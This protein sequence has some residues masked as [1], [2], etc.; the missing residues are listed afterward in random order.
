LSITLQATD[1]NKFRE[2]YPKLSFN[3]K[4]IIYS[5]WYQLFPLQNEFMFD[6]DF[7][8]SVIPQKQKLKV[9]EYGGYEGVLANAYLELYPKSSWVNIELISHVNHNLEE[10][11]YKEIVLD[12]ELWETTLSFTADLFIAEHTIEHL[13]DVECIKFV[14][15]LKK[16]NF[17]TLIIGAPLEEEGQTWRDYYGGHILTFGSKKIRELLE[18]EYVLVTQKHKN[19]WCAVFVKSLC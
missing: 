16:Q 15:W 19:G 13:S 2:L 10:K 17:E 9:V 3:D 6:V 14:E 5:T 11:N 12:K 18:P 1:F 8:A 4:K 7:I